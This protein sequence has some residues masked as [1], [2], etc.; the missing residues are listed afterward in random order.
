MAGTTAVNGKCPE[1]YTH[2]FGPLCVE[3]TTLAKVDELVPDM[4][5]MPDFTD[6][7]CEAALSAIQSI[8]DTLQEVLA[9][10][11]KLMRAAQR[12]LNY[13]FDKAQQLVNGALG[14]LDDVSAA[15]DEALAGPAAAVDELRR[16]L[17]KA[18]DCPFIADSPL[19][20][21]I[22][23]L[24]DAMDAGNPID[25]FI[26]EL[27][28]GLNSA[29]SEALREL[30]KTP[31][32]ALSNAMRLFED[33]LERA[34]V[35]DLLKQLQELEACV[36]AACAAYDVANRLPESASSIMDSLNATI[37]NTTGKL[38]A[39]VVRP[40]TEADRVATQVASDMQL[41]KA[42]VKTTG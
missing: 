4:P 7:A 40:A 34:G 16:V 22:A 11:R 19:G 15:I 3:S 1:G 35:A 24:L 14:A 9:L 32:E 25:G 29:A 39:A 27:K 31:A 5:E 10:P 38:S 28:R 42:K 21:T 17:R 36:E 6:S 12:L 8:S 41:I 20:R 23:A 37:D 33:A 2:V 18:L 30:K 13:P 26:E